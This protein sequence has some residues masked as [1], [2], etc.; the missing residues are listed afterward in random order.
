M[1][2]RLIIKYMVWSPGTVSVELHD[3][4]K[5]NCFSVLQTDNLFIQLPIEQKQF[6]RE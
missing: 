2:D 4:F 3:V 1:V 6:M 5:R